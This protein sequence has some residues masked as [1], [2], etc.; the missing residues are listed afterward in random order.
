VEP[1]SSQVSQEESQVHGDDHGRGFDQGGE[2]SGDAQEEAPQVE[3]DDDGPIQRQS[4]APHPRVHQMV[5]RDHPVDNILG[6]IQ[7]GVIARSRLTNFCAFYSFI[8]SLEPLSVEQALGDPDWIIAMEEELNNCKR[9]EVWELV[10]RPKQNVIDTKWVFRN[11]QDEFGV[12][13][14]TRQD[15]LAKDILKL[16]A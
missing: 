14:R 1:P 4:Q 10:P 3:D 9:N 16:K 15:L 12:V 13:K 8:S 11:K 2:Q 6:S 7:R 5:Q